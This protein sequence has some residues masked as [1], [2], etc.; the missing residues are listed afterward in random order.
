M[1]QK[2]ALEMVIVLHQINDGFI[3][4]NWQHP[5]CFGFSSN[6]TNVCSGNGKCVS[7]NNCKCNVGFFH[8]NCQHPICFGFS[9]NE[10]KVCSG[11]G[12]CTSPN[13]CKCKE[14]FIKMIYE[15]EFHQINVNVKK[16]LFMKIVNIQFVL[17]FH[18]MKQTFALEMVIVLHLIIVMMD[19]FMKIVNIQFVLVFHQMKQKFA[20]EMVNVF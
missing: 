16:V 19:L 1:K 10:T 9:S 11:N 15:N 4:E 5:I 13:K 20:L 6:E 12:N 2:F 8:E 18:Q 3:H 17:V 14:G 7:P